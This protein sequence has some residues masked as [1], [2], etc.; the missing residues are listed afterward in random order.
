MKTLGVRSKI[1]MTEANDM[2]CQRITNKIRSIPRVKG[3]RSSKD[4]IQ[5]TG[6]SK[7]IL[8]STMAIID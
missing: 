4:S 5:L 6:R 3:D 7:N 2:K 1:A 8:R